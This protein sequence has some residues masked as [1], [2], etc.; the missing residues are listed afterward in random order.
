MV[1]RAEK[2][3]F[4]NNKRSNYKINSIYSYRFR[5]NLIS[6]CCPQGQHIPERTISWHLKKQQN[7]E[8]L[9]KTAHENVFT[10]LEEEQLVEW[11]DASSDLDDPNDD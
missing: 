11:L 2:R 7:G 6:I 3:V 10:K 5:K 4:L 9:K 1:R 8:V